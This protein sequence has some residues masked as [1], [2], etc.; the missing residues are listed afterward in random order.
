MLTERMHDPVMFSGK[1]NSGKTAVTIRP[2]LLSDL[3]ML[4][5]LHGRLSD[6]SLYKRFLRVY[7][8]TV[9]DI[10]FIVNLTKGQGAALIATTR[11]N[12]R[13]LAVGLAY[14]VVEDAHKP[15]TAEPAFVVHDW[16]QGRGIGTRLFKE[17]CQTAVAQQIKAF[18]AIMHPANDTMMRIFQRSGLPR[19]QCRRYGERELT[20]RLQ[21]AVNK[22]NKRMNLD[23]AV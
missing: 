20:I 4:V 16:Y 12:R 14:Y 7:R 22:A 21:P 23:S 5:D 17:L 18:N 1:D 13:E 8:P 19:R 10:A 15:L 6:E 9:K 11:T 3:D 2:V